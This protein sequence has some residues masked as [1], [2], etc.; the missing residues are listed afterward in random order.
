MALATT[1]SSQPV[2][3]LVACGV[4]PSLDSGRVF[5]VE[6]TRLRLL[7]PLT[8]PPRWAA[9]LGAPAVWAG[10]VSDKV[11]VA[12]PRQIAA[13][14]LSQGKVQWRF[15]VSKAGKEARRPDPF[16]NPAEAPD[17]P[18]PS[19]PSLSVFRLVKGRVFCLRNRTELIAIDGDTGA[20][21]WSFSSPPGEINSNLWIG[22]EK[23][24][25]QINK[26]NQLLVL[27]TENGRPVNRAALDENEQLER[28]PLP[29]DE[30]S[31][32]L[33]SDRRTV[34]RFD[35]THG[36]TSWVYQESKEMP[37]NGPPQVLG[38]A[39]TLLVLHD[40]C[41]LIRLDAATG[42]KR[43]LSRLHEDLSERP[44]SIACDLKNLYCVNYENFS[45][46]M[47]QS[48]RAVSLDDGSPVWSCPLSGPENVVWSIALSE[49]SVFAFPSAAQYPK[50]GDLATM[51]V[52]VHRRDDGALIERFVFQTA[53]SD[54]TFKVDP[55]G[56]ILATA[57]GVWA[58]GSKSE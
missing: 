34:K 26:P 41:S 39:E 19:G 56:A 3:T 53:V 33:V 55:R 28:P 37:T 17:R 29:I 49:R 23:A 32:I 54:V 8:G 35:L 38:S 24:L 1:S 30:N 52:I 50:A 45:G 27:S 31:V 2:Q 6:K 14:E 48:L 7:D 57:K 5:L 44:G 20:L 47:R 15:D 51:P 18:E 22:A 36:Q 25:L 43:W 13:L 58:L 40:G 16:A 11:I 12:T 42:K 10:F 9:E 21:D 4:V 46:S